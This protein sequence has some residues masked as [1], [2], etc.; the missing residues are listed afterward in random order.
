MY[1]CEFCGKEWASIKER[2]DCESR[3]YKEQ[4]VQQQR[5]VKENL[6]KEKNRRK[7]EINSLSSEIYKKRAELILKINELNKLIDSYNKDCSNSLESNKSRSETD[8][9]KFLRELFGL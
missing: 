3:C 2:M 8:E 1:K 6:L 5:I 9:Q 7:E 4:E